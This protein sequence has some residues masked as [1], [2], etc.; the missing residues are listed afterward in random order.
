MRLSTMVYRGR[1]APS[2]TGELHFGSMVAAVGSYLDAKVHHGEWI[3]RIEDV[4][5]TRCHQ[6]SALSIIHVLD[7]WGFEWD[8][9]IIYQ[10]Q[11]TEIY[12]E[13][14]NRL[15]KQGIVY[16]CSCSR[17]DLA[18]NPRGIDHAP[19]YLGICRQRTNANQAIRA[20]RIQVPDFEIS[21]EDRLQG[22][23]S[24]NLLHNVGDFVVL[25]ADGLFAYQ[26]AVVVDD[27]EQKVTDVIR[28]ADLLDSTPRQIWLFHCFSHSS[29]TYMH[30]P[31]AVNH[32][33]EKLSKQT[34]AKSI[35][36]EN[37]ILLL[38]QVLLFLGIKIDNDICSLE[39]LWQVAIEKWRIANI[40]KLKTIEVPNHIGDKPC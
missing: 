31:V 26:F 14:F 20:W 1:F 37:P 22:K 4:D 5:V 39:E 21:F 7:K 17:K 29:P 12:R 10:S 13:Y 23:Q 6:E 15:K 30:L 32:F 18:K 2:P 40:P 11:R 8:G 9:P 19:L 34:F 27:I 24:Q 33:H 3:L 35:A 16:G 28:G 25:R 36:H 38:K